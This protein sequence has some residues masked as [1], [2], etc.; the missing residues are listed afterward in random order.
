MSKEKREYTNFK[1]STRPSYP[2]LGISKERLR[3][4]QNCCRVG[5]YSSETLSKA[6]RGLEFIKPWVLLSVTKSKSYDLIE[7]SEMGRIPVGRSD[8]YGFRRKFYHNLDC[9][10]R[11]EQ[12]NAP[13]K[14][15]GKR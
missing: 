4:L 14:E 3:E 10:L 15:R 7:Y 11:A 5:I 2:E 13:V 6:C 12:E 1:V 8:F 9:L